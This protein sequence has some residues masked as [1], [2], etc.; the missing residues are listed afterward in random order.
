MTAAPY[1]WIKQIEGSLEEMGHIPLWGKAP[2]FPLKKFAIQLGKELELPDL[3]LTLQAT[4]WR[5]P[6][7]FLEGMGR[8][9]LHLTL[10]MLPSAHFHFIL[11][12][13]DL[14]HLISATLAHET[15]TKSF[16]DKSLSEGYFLY[17]ATEA[18]QALADIKAYPDISLRL[19]PKGHLPKETALCVDVGIQVKEKPLTGRLIFSSAFLHTFRRHFHTKPRPPLSRETRQ[20]IELSLNV[21]LGITH[22]TLGELQKAAVGDVI[23]LDRCQID[24]KTGQGP[25]KIFLQQT[26]LFE[27]QIS[28]GDLT[29]VDYSNY[30]EEGTMAKDH[31]DDEDEDFDDEIDDD[32]DDDV[33][34]D[35]DDFDEDF[36]EDLDDE[37]FDDEDEDFEEEDEEIEDKVKEEN[38]QSQGEH[39]WTPPTEESP[40]EH[41][42]QTG[43]ILVTLTVEQGRV[44]MTLDKLLELKPGNVLKLQSSALQP[45]DIRLNGKKVAQGELIKVGDMLGIK[46]L[47]IKS[48]IEK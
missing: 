46:I 43:K 4:E 5:E 15:L 27:A 38:E 25:I 1:H 34:L 45:L 3:S 39:P 30:H 48:G 44:K 9:P 20:K 7:A 47:Q 6:E 10:D 16:T 41:S 14:A 23:V 18:L 24:P 29:I 33:N 11:P 2:S 37:D 8:S 42:L 19:A 32:F 17:L 28:Q 26:P 13:D 31:I 36:D 12:M 35:D 40:V 22:L 21:Q